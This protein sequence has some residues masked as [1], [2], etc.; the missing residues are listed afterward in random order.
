MPRP[1]SQ[2]GE[3]G[4]LELILKIGIADAIDTLP[5]GIK[6]DRRAVAETIANNVRSKILKSH[7]LDPAYYDRMSVLLGEILVDLREKRSSYEDFLRR[8]AEL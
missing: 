6:R 7:L 4:L 1:I 8:I 2:F 5:E 3:L